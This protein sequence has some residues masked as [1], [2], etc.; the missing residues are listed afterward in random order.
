MTAFSKINNFV[1]E[2]LF[3]FSACLFCPFVAYET[4]EN[5]V[6]LHIDKRG[7]CKMYMGIKWNIWWEHQ[8]N[9]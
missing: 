7:D 2:P 9:S 4:I 5:G 1:E 3:P 6:W 8:N